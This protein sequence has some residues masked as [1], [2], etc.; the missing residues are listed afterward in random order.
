MAP[1]VQYF[2]DTTPFQFIEMGFHPAELRAQLPLLH[3]ILRIPGLA[4]PTEEHAQLT[5]NQKMAYLNQI[6]KILTKKFLTD[7]CVLI[8]DDLQW[9][10]GFSLSFLRETAESGGT[11]ILASRVHQVSV[12]KRAHSFLSQEEHLSRTSDDSDEGEGLSHFGCHEQGINEVRAFDDMLLSPLVHQF[13]LR[14]LSTKSLSGLCC[15]LIGCERMCSTLEALLAQKSDGRPGFATQIVAAL[16]AAGLVNVQGKTAFAT[17]GR[18]YAEVIVHSVPTVEAQVLQVMDTLPDYQ[19]QVAMMLAVLGRS[20]VELLEHCVSSNTGAGAFS[21]ALKAL[22]GLNLLKRAKVQN[23]RPPGRKSMGSSVASQPSET[24]ASS[25]DLLSQGQAMSS[26]RLNKPQL[27]V[28][29]MQNSSCNGSESSYQGDSL[30]DEVRFSLSLARDVIYYN[31]LLKVRRRLH[32]VVVRT[33][34][35][36]VSLS[37]DVFCEHLSKSAITDEELTNLKRGAFF[38]RKECDDINGCL[39]AYS[40][41]LS[42]AVRSTKLDVFTLVDVGLHLECGHINKAKDILSQ[43]RFR[44]VSKC[45]RNT[46]EESTTRC[47]CFKG[48]PKP[49]SEPQPQVLTNATCLELQYLFLQLETELWDGNVGGI[50]KARAGLLQISAMNPGYVELADLLAAVDTVCGNTTKFS[51]PPSTAPEVLKRMF[52]TASNVGD[53]EVSSEGD[54]VPHNIS[55][56]DSMFLLPVENCQPHTSPKVSEKVTCKKRGTLY[57]PYLIMAATAG[58]DCLHVLDVVNRSQ[59]PA[60]H[61]AVPAVFAYCKTVMG[62]NLFFLPIPLLQERIL[63]ALHRPV[64]K[65]RRFSLAASVERSF[66]MAGSNSGGKNY[67]PAPVTMLTSPDLEQRSSSGERNSPQNRHSPTFNR[68]RHRP[69]FATSM[70][71]PKS[72]SA[73][74]AR[75]RKRPSYKPGAVDNAETTSS[76]QGTTKGC[77][78]P[79]GGFPRRSLKEVAVLCLCSTVACLGEQ[80]GAL[81][82][83]YFTGLGN[84][85]WPILLVVHKLSTVVSCSEAGLPGWLMHMNTA[86]SRQGCAHAQDDPD[87]TSQ[88]LQMA[89]QGLVFA[90]EG[91]VWDVRATLK[92]VQNNAAVV[93]PLHGLALFALSEALMLSMQL[94]ASGSED[95]RRTLSKTPSS[96][97]DLLDE[98][99]PEAFLLTHYQGDTSN[100]LRAMLS[101]LGSTAALYPGVSPAFNLMM[102]LYHEDLAQK[103]KHLVD[104]LRTSRSLGAPSWYV[105]FIVSL[106]TFLQETAVRGS[107]SV[108]PYSLSNRLKKHTHTVPWLFVRGPAFS[109]SPLKTTTTQT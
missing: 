44:R 51:N 82:P 58:W 47:F 3:H 16:L 31:S 74:I 9:T 83:H 92:H 88:L 10:D 72:P 41:P 65:E 76:A 4:L 27:R 77:A 30:E 40:R 66:M 6:L 89:L 1:L 28:S 67:E 36:N 26:Y 85:A 80:V 29:N 96:Y 87:A 84:T 7:R 55:A 23:V 108:Q 53:L 52:P 24:Q 11:L 99:C 32:S 25:G 21:Q 13:V 38:E 15:A 43:V 56:P 73:L 78:L 68:A 20:S 12:R 109:F 107:N 8:V 75:S 63:E 45:A 100:Y 5:S 103:R 93:T 18:E 59:Q 57:S 22:Q 2:M 101:L 37:N 33:V 14:G 70:H 61:N 105:I 50:N 86:W 42:Q 102:A 91:R 35:G 81:D 97:L 104:V 106:N 54:A 79:A 62:G 69:S 90:R 19:R 17:E 95:P 46:S 94:D 71:N 39:A 98:T 34:V 60:V 48:E 49:V 64:L